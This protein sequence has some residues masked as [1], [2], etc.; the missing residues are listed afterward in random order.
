M[1]IIYGSLDFDLDDEFLS[2]QY[3]RETFNNPNDVKQW[4]ENSYDWVRD[5]TGELCDMRKA[6][7]SWNE[8]VIEYFTKNFAWSDIGTS[9]YKMQGGV[10]L[11][12]HQDTYKKYTEV[13]NLNGKEESIYRAIVFLQNWDSGHYAEYNGSILPN[14]KRGDYVVWNYDTPHMAA[15]IGINPRYTLQVTGHVA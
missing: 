15:N 14:W 8:R 7:P 13:F 2:L 10:I 12:T 6:Q 9:Y 1:N 4:V 11:P 5:F 3:D